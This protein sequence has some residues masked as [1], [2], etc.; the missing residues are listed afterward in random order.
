[1]TP[2]N[3][4]A[5]RQRGTTLLV[6]LVMLV[7]ITLFGIAGIRMS[8]S[9][10][11]VVGNMQARKQV[12]NIG[13]QTIE[14]IVNSIAY[15]N[16]PNHST[17]YTMTG[18]PAGY[19]ATAGPRTCVFAAPATGY[20]AVAALAPQDNNWEFEVNVTDGFTGAKTKMVQ[21]V[22]IRQLA[23]YCVS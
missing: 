9:N 15:F 3:S 7:V 23:G 20:S 19:T 5:P 22:R 21:G 1:M 2:S 13:Q 17:T 16:T 10:L 4:F 11:I 12:E 14:Q 8:S 6:V 18:L